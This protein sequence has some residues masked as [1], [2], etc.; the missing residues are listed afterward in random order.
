MPATRII[1]FSTLFVLAAAHAE[2]A[3]S[4]VA[5]SGARAEATS[6]EQLA[7]DALQKIHL[8]D[9]EEAQRLHQ[10]ARR[11]QPTMKKLLLVEGL[12]YVA[13]GRSAVA[14]YPL[15]EYNTTDQGKVDYRGFAAIGKIY[16]QS[17]MYRSATR[18]LES[19]KDLAKREE[20]GE[21]VRA[22]I[23]IDLARAYLGLARIKDAVKTAQEAQND[24][25]DDGDIQ[26]Q[27]SEIAVSANEPVLA[28]DAANRATALLRETVRADPFDIDAHEKLRRCYQVIGQLRGAQAASD[29]ATGQHL[30][31]HAQILVQAAE[32]D[33]R[34]SA[35]NARNQMLRAIEKDPT[36]IDWQFFAARLEFDLGAIA[37]AKQRIDRI[38]GTQPD[39]AGA[40]QLKRR[41]ESSPSADFLP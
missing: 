40:L 32:V 34:I 31:Q 4:Q 28:E 3:E 1:R 8:G 37:E 2:R 19:A 23:A 7:D 15:Q 13:G 29:E 35:L 27:V 14:L 36:N 17:Y 10:L 39:H 5:P 16:L 22:N 6:P 30:F 21:P 41:I 18:P 9:L 25:L 24:A 26:V 38:L 12:L 33:R 20:Y 11:M